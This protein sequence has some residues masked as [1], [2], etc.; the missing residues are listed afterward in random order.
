MKRR[1]EGYI[2]IYVLVVVVVLCAIVTG[3]CTVALRNLQTQ[4]RSIQRTR[5]LYEAEGA[6]EELIAQL[7]TYETGVQ[8]GDEGDAKDNFEAYAKGRPDITA[9]SK[10]LE[11]DQTTWKWEDR[12]VNGDTKAILLIPIATA[13][14]DSQ[15]VISTT[16]EVLP[17]IKDKS[18]TKTETIDGVEAEVTE[19]KYQISGAAVTY[20]S[21]QII[22]QAEASDET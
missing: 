12:D 15:I 8:D 17:H 1:D 11:T 5:A 2:L 22:D 21:Y 7:E 10:K 19:E 13:V 16:L 9:A 20:T 14:P 4:E 18:T 6:I 3:V